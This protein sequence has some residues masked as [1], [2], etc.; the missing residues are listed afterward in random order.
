MFE[1]IEDKFQTDFTHLRI[2]DHIDGPFIPLYYERELL[3]YVKHGKILI[4]SLKSSINWFL[5]NQP[6]IT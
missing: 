4:S 6:L 1:E 2:H 5:I 3:S